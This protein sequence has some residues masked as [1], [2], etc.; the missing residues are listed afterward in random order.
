ML[1]DDA[2]TILVIDAKV[3]RIIAKFPEFQACVHGA[4]ERASLTHYH[5]NYFFRR[6]SGHSLS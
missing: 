1:T 6:F 3:F 5:P 4:W 2:S